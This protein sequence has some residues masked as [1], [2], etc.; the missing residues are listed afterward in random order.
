MELSV[1]IL[2]ISELSVKSE[3]II[4]PKIR[5]IQHYSFQWYFVRFIPSDL[6]TNRSSIFDL[7]GERM[8]S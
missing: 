5:E 1:E 4:I 2:E 7:R 6:C 3:G 8:E